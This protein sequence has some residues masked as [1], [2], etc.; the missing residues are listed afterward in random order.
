MR[1]TR[2]ALAAMIVAGLM[3]GAASA[4]EP[5]ALAKARNLYNEGN[6]EGAI[7]AAAVSRRQAGWADQSALVIGRSYLELYHQRADPKDLAAAREALGTVRK[8]A[9]TPRDQVDLIIGMGL[10]LYREE[11]FGA[12]ANLFDT[13]LTRGSVLSPRDRR[14][15]LDWW[16]SA[17]DRQ[18]QAGPADRRRAMFERIGARMDDELKQ[19]PGSSVA[20]YWRAVAARGSGDLQGAWDYAIAGWV[21]STLEPETKEDL[22]GDMDRLVQQALIPERSRLM[23]RDPQEAVSTLRADW[24]LVKQ[25]WK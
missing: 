9:L 10:A 18:A 1:T 16:A 15:L 2:I 3:T 17:L 19:D 11:V 4:A 5:P 12:A 20:L 14:Q 13:A 25:Q 7:D 8:D 21:Q 6:Y 24:E 23:A 22:R